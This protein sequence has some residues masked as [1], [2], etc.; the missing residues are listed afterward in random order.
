[1]PSEGTEVAQPDQ[2]GQSR[3]GETKQ[4]GQSTQW[5]WESGQSS[6]AAVRGD[7][8]CFCTLLKYPLGVSL[9]WTL[10]P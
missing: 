5:V 6:I 4:S 2:S 9:R 1:M 8:L 10:C 3:Q 7:F